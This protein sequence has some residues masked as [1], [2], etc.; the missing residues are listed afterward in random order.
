MRFPVRRLL[1]AAG[2]ALP[3]PAPAQ[4]A[5]LVTRVPAARLGDD[6]PVHEAWPQRDLLPGARFNAA[7]QSPDGYLWLATSKGLLRFDGARAV[8]A[9]PP[10]FDSLPNPE[11]LTVYLGR[12]GA[13]WAGTARAGVF[14][15]LNGAYTR[16]TTAQGLPSDEVHAVYQDSAGRTWI[17]TQRGLCRVDGAACR[18][19]G[20]P[21]VSV[22]ALGADWDCRLLV[23]SYGLFRLDGDRFDQVPGLAPVLYRVIRIR[24]G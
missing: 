8:R 16:W 7:V 18:P 22:L 23:G 19:V 20:P 3:H 9:M 24:T 13:I 4:R 6:P 14:R 10:F 1:L 17:G 21:N 2:L 12:H 5:P 11:V 15:L